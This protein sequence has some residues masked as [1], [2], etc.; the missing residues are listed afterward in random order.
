MIGKYDKYYDYEYLPDSKSFYFEY[1]VCA[2]MENRKFA[3]FNKEMFGA[4]EKN[5][6][7][8]IIIDLRNNSGGNSEI[9]NPFT[10]SL[11]SYVQKNAKVKVYTLIGRNTF[12]SGMF[13][14]YRVKEAAPGL[15]L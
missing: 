13:A 12:S 8:K 2:D 5:H 15:Y 4:I 3:D 9:L 7:D 11:K 1:N 10:K 6:I 14:I